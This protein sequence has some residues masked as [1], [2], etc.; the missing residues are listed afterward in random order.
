MLRYEPGG[1]YLHHADSCLFELADR[2]WYKVQDRDLSM[3]IYLNDDF[4]GGGLTFVKFNFHYRPRVGFTSGNPQSVQ[5]SAERPGSALRKVQGEFDTVPTSTRHTRS[6][7]LACTPTP[8]RAASSP[9]STKR[10]H[11]HAAASDLAP[12]MPLMLFRFQ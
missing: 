11:P 10:L 9:V 6:S 3:L 4:V 5:H 7:F 12:A 1:F 2:T 8:L